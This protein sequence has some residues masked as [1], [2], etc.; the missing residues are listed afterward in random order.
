MKRVKIM[1]MAIAV[2]AVIGAALAFKVKYHTGVVCT[3][4]AFYNSVAHT[5]YCPTTLPCPDITAAFL[6]EINPTAPTVCYT[7][8]FE[9]TCID[10]AL[11]LTCATTTQLMGEF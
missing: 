7:P 9:G 3:T 10:E 2:L 8:A 6:D 11:P 5:Y 4:K 1:L